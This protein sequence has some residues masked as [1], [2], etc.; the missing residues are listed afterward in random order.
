MWAYLGLGLSMG[1]SAGISPGPLLALVITASLR[2]GLKGGLLV[3]L[4]PLIT[5][6]PIIILSVVLANRLPRQPFAGW[7]PRVAWC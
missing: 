2:S 4:A 5:D 7:A 6:A 3:A 1:L